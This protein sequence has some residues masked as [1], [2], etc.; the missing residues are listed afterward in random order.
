MPSA[1][2]VLASETVRRSTQ[3]CSGLPKSSATCS[4]AVAIT[5]RS[6]PSSV[7]S[8][9]LAKSLSITAGT[10]W[11]RPSSSATT[12]I[13]PPPTVMTTKPASASALTAGSSTMR[14]GCGEATTTRLPRPASSTTVQPSARRRAAASSSRNDP[15]GLVGLA[16]AGSFGVDL[17]LRHDRDGLPVEP[18]AGELVPERLLELVAD[19]ALRVGAADVERH[20]VQL[21][22]RTARTAAG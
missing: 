19:G 2:Y 16:N 21:V 10:P 12:G 13:P 7:A 17:G 9:E 20:L 14:I 11:R 8:S 1:R 5:N 15:I 3:R 6:A 22:R 4:T 18:A